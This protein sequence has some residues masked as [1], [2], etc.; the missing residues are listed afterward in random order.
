MASTPTKENFYLLLD[1]PFDPPEHDPGVIAAAVK[2]K[3]AEWSK[4]RNHPT[5][6]RKAQQ[7]LGLLP[8]IKR[9]MA[10]DGLRKLQASEARTRHAEA[11]KEKFRKLDA[12]IKLLS[13]KGV[14]YEKEIAA[15]AKK[16]PL[17][18]EA[19]IRSRI[20]VKIEKAHKAKPKRQAL[21]GTTAAA[22]SKALDIID[23][24]S[25]YDF[26][27]VA[28]SSSLKTLQTRTRDVDAQLRRDS[29][30]GAENTAK[31]E[32][33]G[34]CLNLFKTDAAKDTYDAALENAG[35]KELHDHIETGRIEGSISAAMFDEL[36][37]RAAGVGLGKKDAQDYI[38]DYCG[39]KKIAVTMPGK[40]SA[41]EMKQ[42]GFC[43]VINTPDAVNCSDCGNSLSI[44][45]PKCAGKNPTTSRV[46]VKCG[47]FVGDMPNAEKLLQE[48]KHAFAENDLDRA[49]ILLKQAEVYW[50]D[51]PE[52]VRLLKEIDL[53]GRAI[54]ACAAELHDLVSKR[55]FYQ[56]RQ[57]LSKLA[58][59]APGHPDL[60]FEVQIK[61]K[62]AAAEQWV[63]K[64]KAAR[65]SDDAIDAYVSAMMECEDCR[66]AADGLSKT[67]P[68]ET[69]GVR[70]VVSR[71]SISLTWTP[72]KTR[73]GVDYRVVRKEGG[74]P[75][76]ADDGEVLA[77]TGQTT[78][79][80]T[81]TAPGVSYYYAVYS[82]RKG[83]LSRGCAATGPLMQVDEAEKLKIV[84]GD[85]A[86]RLSWEVPTRATGVEVW[87]KRGGVPTARGDGT[88]ESHARRDGLSVSDLKNGFVYG[89]LISAV[90]EDAKGN[91]IYSKGV[92]CN[93]KPVKPPSPIRD[94][95]A[96]KI[97]NNIQLSW[98][99]PRQGSVLIFHSP[100]SFECVEGECL[101]A[102]AL[103]GLGSQ[104]DVHG[105]GQVMIPLKFQGTLHVLPVVQVGSVAVM[106][107]AGV[108][109]SISEVKNLKGEVNSGRMY[110]EW[111][112]PAGARQ[113]LVAAGHEAFPTVPGETGATET[114]VTKALYDKEGG[115]VIRKPEKKDYYF[116]V[117]V[118][119][120]SQ[121]NKIYSSG[122]PFL[123]S[124]KEPVKLFYE[125]KVG[126]SLFGRIKSAKLIIDGGGD[127]VV[128]PDMVLVKK[129]GRLPLKKGDGPVVFSVEGRKVPAHEKLEFDLPL[130]E[131]EHNGYGR[132]FFKDE[133]GAKKIRLTSKGKE[134]QKLYA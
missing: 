22:I 6:Q 86:L 12:A 88:R 115:F 61:R 101:P 118:C 28:P 27:G 116:S 17:V 78:L 113:V 63:R 112:W 32:L 20:K 79:E 71:R 103:G 52:A 102:S 3:Q 54:D 45:C 35:Y 59:Q 75:V 95:R 84:P 10:D 89:Y 65:R 127:T 60:S 91:R 94:L 53:R 96:K 92:T 21:D 64:A 97:K 104:I 56:A 83:V 69:T 30:K 14:I 42:C 9:V 25:L 106:G 110:L 39:K 11:E 74:V 49:S 5:K 24:K 47:F 120:E 132:L 93:G 73:G 68:P 15:I 66:E 105:K 133:E 13:S 72:V 99:H 76:N 70:A 134:R 124:N 126:K 121:G 46:C 82:V 40:L 62:I 36:V 109:T 43:G 1:L 44:S 108:V 41:D 48:G 130:G 114:V 119:A 128:I 80:D 107:R 50:P 4:L 2:R 37:K 34:H 117:F 123:I 100:K 18:P 55:L 57:V 90:Y 58:R 122:S 26:L 129:S 33:T 31:G 29:N 23:K 51:H 98:T 125:I 87:S 85:G 111:D 81:G 77:E 19:D 7:Y 67:P 16:F 131:L 38:L 8:E